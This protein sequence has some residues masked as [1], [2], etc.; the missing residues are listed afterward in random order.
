VNF[1]IR[2]IE[3]GCV[4]KLGKK[5]FSFNSAEG[6]GDFILRE[7][8]MDKSVTLT[9][10]MLGLYVINCPSDKKISCIKLIRELSGRGLKEAKDV[11]DRTTLEPIVIDTNMDNLRSIAMRI[12]ENT[13]AELA[14]NPVTAGHPINYGG[15]LTN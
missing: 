1:S 13:G 11:A 2:K 7:L 9:P 12:T 4:L 10:V 14:I 8:D 5:E 3:N 6:L 15:R